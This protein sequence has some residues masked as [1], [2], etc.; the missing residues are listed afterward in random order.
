MWRGSCE[1][2]VMI[3]EP[4]FEGGCLCGSVRWRATRVPLYAYHCHCR[5][6]QRQS[7]AA[8]ITGVTFHMNALQWTVGEPHLFESSQNAKRG[9]C[10]QCGSW[11]SWQWLEEK[12]S[13]TAGSF[14]HPEN[15]NPQWH[16]FTEGR[17]P[18]LRLN[19]GLP[20]CTRYPSEIEGQDQ[21]L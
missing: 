14:D 4:I 5:M 6:C 12:I 21:E 1:D 13:M 19:D 17:V 2:T 15:I 20:Q 11:L 7:G 18:W 10:A 3:M 16:V 9:F 8:F